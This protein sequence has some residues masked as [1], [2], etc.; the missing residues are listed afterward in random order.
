MQDQLVTAPTTLVVGSMS[1]DIIDVSGY[2]E[3]W[4]RVMV[5]TIAPGAKITVY[6]EES[7]DQVTWGAIAGAEIII[8]EDDSGKVKLGLY[9]VSVANARYLRVSS[10]VDGSDTPLTILLTLDRRGGPLGSLVFDL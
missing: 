3:A 4:L 10:T 6:L 9:R 2:W 1:G 7:K 5:G 8:Y